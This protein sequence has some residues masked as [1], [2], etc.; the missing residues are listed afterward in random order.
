MQE[1]GKSKFTVYVDYEKGVDP[2][3]GV[4]ELMEEFGFVVPNGKGYYSLASNMEKKY[5]LKALRDNVDG[6]LE[7]FINDPEFRKMAE[8]KYKL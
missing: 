4:F 8:E 5:R 2:Y 1:K 3:S 7:K 6:I